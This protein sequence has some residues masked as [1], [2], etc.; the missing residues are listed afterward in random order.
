M[1]GKYDDIINLPHH[2]SLVHPHMSPVERAAQFSPFAALTGYEA[3]IE[4]AGRL[5]D[6]R[7]EITEEQEERIDAALRLACGADRPDVTITCFMPDEFKD[8]GE[9]VN[10][11][12]KIKKADTAIG[13]LI[14]ENGTE[15]WLDDITDA[16]C[17]AESKN[18][19]N[20]EDY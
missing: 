8:G 16:V 4:E 11:T 19:F 3:C 6:S 17:E 14:M 10:I 9:F 7:A 1:S 5:T 15:I 13:K 20:S 2:R 18:N 12:G